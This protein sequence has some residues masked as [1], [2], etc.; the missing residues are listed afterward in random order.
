MMRRNDAASGKRR[1]RTRRRKDAASGKRRK[2]TRRRKDAASGRR[3]R[4]RRIRK[5]RRRVN[6]RSGR[7]RRRERQNY[8]ENAIIKYIVIK[9]N[10]SKFNKNAKRMRSSDD[11]NVYKIKK[12]TLLPCFTPI[13]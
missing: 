4:R 12:K 5:K 2:R 8:S 3:R 1:K 13:L 7:R 10:L 11:K 9:K 6:T